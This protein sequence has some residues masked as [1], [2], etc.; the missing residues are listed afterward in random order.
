LQA[1]GV[2][3]TIPS[4]TTADSTYLVRLGIQDKAFVPAAAQLAAEDPTWI[5][6]NGAAAGPNGNGRSL[7][8]VRYPPN[9]NTADLGRS[10]AFGRWDSGAWFFPRNPFSCAPLWRYPS[11]IEIVSDKLQSHDNSLTSKKHASRY[12]FFDKRLI[13]DHHLILGKYW[14]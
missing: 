2:P 5:L 13:S 6:G 7:V 14:G 4:L 3:G 1:A 10:N 11:S 8:P 9:Q 12:H